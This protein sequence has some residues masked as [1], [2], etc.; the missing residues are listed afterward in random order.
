[1]QGEPGIDPD[2][3]GVWGSSFAGGNV[4]VTA[5]LDSRVKA[6]VGQVPA[7]SGKDAPIAPAASRPGA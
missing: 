4:I 2:R 5:A 7:I 1:L 3:I 6:V